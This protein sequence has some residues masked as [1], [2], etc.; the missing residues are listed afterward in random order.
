MVARETGAVGSGKCQLGAVGSADAG[1]HFQCTVSAPDARAVVSALGAEG[2]TASTHV[3]VRIGALGAPL[4]AL[5][6][7]SH[8]EVFAGIAELC[9]GFSTASLTLG[10]ALG[11]DASN[12]DVRLLRTVQHQLEGV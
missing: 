6:G 2:W 12:G 5:Q 10:V 3:V 7:G 9:T 4:H 8:A 11:R 1:G